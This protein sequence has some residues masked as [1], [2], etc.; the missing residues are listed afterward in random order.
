MGDSSKKKPTSHE[1]G[2]VLVVDDEAHMRATLE[3]I[4]S[5]EFK[6]ECAEGVAEALTL[7]GTRP[8]DVV[9][10][11]YEL[12]DGTGSSLLTEVAARHPDVTSI[13][14]T[15]N[16]S[17][18]EVK[19]VQHEGRTLVIWKPVNPADLIGWVRNAV[20]IAR[21]QQVLAALRRKS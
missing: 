1:V 5:Q 15:G 3:A 19:R 17:V 7:L 6:V 2:R 9:V 8:F 10:A 4:L 16:A 20:A 21:L 14:V 11:D 18:P 12:R 13:I